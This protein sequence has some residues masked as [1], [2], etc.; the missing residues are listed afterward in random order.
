MP[1]AVPWNEQLHPRGQPE[2]AGQFAEKPDARTRKRRS[3]G[4][5]SHTDERPGMGLYVGLGNA[6][7]INDALRQN[8]TSELAPELRATIADLTATI[9]ASPLPSSLTVFRGWHG[10]V[11]W[12]PGDVFID[13]AFVSTSYY[14]HVAQFHAKNSP[15]QQPAIMEIALPAGARAAVV[16]GSEEDEVLIQRGSR[17]RIDSVAKERGHVVIRA[18]LVSQGD[19]TFE[20]D[21]I[22]DDRVAGDEE[23][24]GLRG[25]KGHKAT[26]ASRLITAKKTKDAG[27][28]LQP[29]LAAMKT[30]PEA[31]ERNMALFKID[32]IYPNFVPKTWT[33]RPTKPPSM[34]S[35]R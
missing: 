1:I 3:I 11:N 6:F 29:S 19:E 22:E 12:Q 25:N 27:T 18:T 2:N 33:A 7:T 14:R 35:G 32:T 20:A 4:K 24:T 26:I 9:D 21:E 31:F 30:D 15:Q 13:P 8:T 17:F 28:Y 16:A 5:G 34:S 10:P 23:E